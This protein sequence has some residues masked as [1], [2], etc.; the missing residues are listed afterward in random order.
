MTGSGGRAARR[1]LVVMLSA[2]AAVTCAVI[3]PAAAATQTPPHSLTLTGGKSPFYD[4]DLPIVGG[5]HYLVFSD[6]PYP[7]ATQTLR[8]RTSTG[9]TSTL[10]FDPSSEEEP[11]SLA[12]SSLTGADDFEST[13]GVVQNNVEW[14][15]LANGTSGILDLPRPD[16]YLGS[17]PD[18]ILAIGPSGV[19]Q[20]HP[21][22]GQAATKLGTP[23][24]S[25][26]TGAVPVA[27]AADGGVVLSESGAFVYMSWKH[28]GTFTGLDVKS[29]GDT[30]AFCSSLAAGNAGCGATDS[31][32]HPLIIRAPVSGGAPVVT[33]LAK[34]ACPDEVIATASVTAWGDGCLGTIDSVPGTTGSPVSSSKA[35]IEE[36]AGLA[37]AY[38]QLIAAVSPG[39]RFA[40]DQVASATATR[41]RIV[42][43]WRSAVVAA[44]I[45]LS[46]G[47]IAY[48]DDQSAAVTTWTRVLG[49]TS[50]TVTAG[51]A[52]SLGHPGAGT[53]I[54][55]GGGAHLSISGANTASAGL[56]H[57]L[58]IRSPIRTTTLATKSVAEDVEM[59]GNRVVF[60]TGAGPKSM[61]Y[62]LR[63]GALTTIS[64]AVSASVWGNYLAIAKADGSV[65]RQQLGGHHAP[66]ELRAPLPA[67]Q[68]VSFFV[69]VYSFGDFVA[70]Q[71]EAAIAT[72]PF[73]VSHDGYR[74]A[75]TMAAAQ[76]IPDTYF[77]RAATSDGL[78]EQHYAGDQV[79]YYLQRY[80]STKRVQVLSTPQTGLLAGN[81]N[82]VAV[83][84]DRIAWVDGTNHARVAPLPIAT[85]PDPPR[86]LGDAQAPR[87]AKAS[88]LA[89]TPW[90]A[91]IPLSA[92]LTTCTVTIYAG[93]TAVRTL[94]CAKSDALLGDAAVRWDGKDSGGHALGAGSY[95]WQLSAAN[96][97]GTALAADGSAAA[98]RGRIVLH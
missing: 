6:Q 19:L 79:T 84:G 42:T 81:P 83:D 85:S 45:A 18:G 26:P 72:P 41:H 50:A 64:G 8:L 39:G 57:S 38:G 70:W 71:L 77:P 96:S 51:S 36:G 90:Q 97:D 37:G 7:Y 76:S 30:D 93:S 35:F 54:D 75:R 74:N 52:T 67:K 4:L 27:L 91:F 28:P 92:A 56:S 94:T 55:V 47:R 13:P 32:G 12:G 60:D 62:D 1:R 58:S 95:R 49:G 44:N 65:W 16:A 17:A 69:Q 23:F 15:N 24:P 73:Q 89:K 14:W 40:L 33:R 5:A 98:I 3:A 43:P 21:A 66:V 59:S 9:T 34:S 88:G 63:T 61:L 80:G 68:R 82:Q 53:D 46:P 29:A 31:T 78:L 2:I 22:T 11:T 25:A 10:A 87:T 20:D 86:F 48:D